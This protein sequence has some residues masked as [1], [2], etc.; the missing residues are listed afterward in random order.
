MIPPLDVMHSSSSST[1]HIVPQLLQL[2]LFWATHDPPQQSSPRLLM[3]GSLHVSV[4]LQRHWL[5]MQLGFEPPHSTPQPPQFEP[6]DV[7]SMQLPLQQL[8]P[9]PHEAPVEP[10]THCPLTQLSP[11]AQR[12]PLSPQLSGFV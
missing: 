5:S 2:S 12:S 8:S 4:A 9:S 1:L 7:V 10:Q 3:L 11:S 6:S